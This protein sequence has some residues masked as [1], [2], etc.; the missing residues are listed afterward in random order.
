MAVIYCFGDS[1]TYGAWDIEKGGWANRL[2]SYVDMLQSKND[3]LYYLLYNLGIP[4]ENT[5]AFLRR[6]ESELASRTKM[7]RGALGPGEAL[8]VFAF[9]AN[10]YVYLP[11][12]DRFVVPQDTFVQNL[13][14]AIVLAQKS[15]SRIFLLNITPADENICAEK[16]GNRKVRLNKNV[17]I[18]NKLIASICEKNKCILIDV[19]A[20]FTSSQNVL[21]E[22]GLHPNDSGHQ[23]IFEQVKNAIE[24]YI[25]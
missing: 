8:F 14:Q 21:S 12:E 9:G 13:E 23:L 24:K 2:R 25:R 10:D 11:Q 19:Y 7:G 16:Y 18:Y 20:P 4:G 1:I 3:N 22:D 5:D 15:S 17:E 6:F